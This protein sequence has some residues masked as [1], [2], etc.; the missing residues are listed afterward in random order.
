VGVPT[1]AIGDRVFWGDDRL[2]EA[3]RALM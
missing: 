2:S 3:A 1:I